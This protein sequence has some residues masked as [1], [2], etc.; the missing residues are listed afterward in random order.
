MLTRAYRKS[1]LHPKGKASLW[2]QLFN[3]INLITFHLFIDCGGRK[4]ILGLL[5]LI[6]PSSIHV[7][8]FSPTHPS[9]HPMNIF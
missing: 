1:S 4:E 9:I 2:W 3:S 5:L 6:Y 7:A 8:I